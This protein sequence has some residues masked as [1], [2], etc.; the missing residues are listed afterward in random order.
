M[1]L[2]LVVALGWVWGEGVGG[3]FSFL[4][5]LSVSTLSVEDKP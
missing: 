3:V 4:F 5:F 2:G 1:F